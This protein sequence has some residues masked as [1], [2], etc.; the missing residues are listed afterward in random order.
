MRKSVK[1]DLRRAFGFRTT[2]ADRDPV[3]FPQ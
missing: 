2:T 3:I 1:P